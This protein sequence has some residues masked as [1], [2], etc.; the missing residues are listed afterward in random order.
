MYRRNN[1]SDQ[2][3]RVLE[4]VENNIRENHQRSNNIGRGRVPGR[5]RLINRNPVLPVSPIFQND[6]DLD[7]LLDLDNPG[8]TE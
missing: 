4:K 5:H 7:D 3:K 8:N 1:L 6:D 2:L